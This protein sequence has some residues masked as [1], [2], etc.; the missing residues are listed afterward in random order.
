MIFSRKAILGF[1]SS[2]IVEE[3]IHYLLGSRRNY[4]SEIAYILRTN[5]LR[6]ASRY[7]RVKGIAI[8]LV[9]IL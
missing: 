3:T 1:R 5:I 4:I 6:I 9:T 7:A 8:R 2:R